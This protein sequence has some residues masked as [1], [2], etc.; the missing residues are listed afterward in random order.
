SPLTICTARFGTP[1]ARARKATSASFAAPS[2]GGATTRT[3]SAPSRSP[4]ISVFLARGMTRTFSSTNDFARR[5]GVAR[6]ARV[7]V[8]RAVEQ[9]AVVAFARFLLA[10]ELER[11]PQRGNAR[12]D[13]R[14]D[15]LALQAEAVDLA[16]N[17]L[18]P[19]LRLLEQHVGP[20]L[21]LADD[22]LG[23]VLG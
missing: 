10:Y 17:V 19:G 14:L 6:L 7:R 8:A 22:A 2:T 20:P 12:L 1:S 11:V 16:L 9:D 4:E 3:T 5:V 23:L 18:E 21:G 13:R 15:V